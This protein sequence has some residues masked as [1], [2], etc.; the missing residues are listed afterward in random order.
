M[1]QPNSMI[2]L[3]QKPEADF[4]AEHVRALMPDLKIRCMT[5]ETD[6]KQLAQKLPQKPC[7]LFAFLTPSYVPS[8]LLSYVDSAFNVHPGPPSRP[9]FRPTH[10]A[11]HDTDPKHGVTLFQMTEQVDEGLIIASQKIDIS[12][13]KSLEKV[14]ELT[15]I[16][17]VQLAL[18]NL[19]VIAGIKNP[20]PY[21][22]EQWS[23]T[24]MSH[25]DWAKLARK[26]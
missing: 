19:K 12:M 18:A 8:E 11:Y 22:G 24:K 17:A 2:L 26:G 23:G 21:T 1:K 16:A 9:G 20:A 14:E 15:Y 7:R 6:L 13:A 5:S 25:S 10:F 4:F 3:M